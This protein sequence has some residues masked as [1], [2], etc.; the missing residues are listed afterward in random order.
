MQQDIDKKKEETEKQME[1]SAENTKL[2]D[3]MNDLQGKRSV[4]I[5]T[6]WM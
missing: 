3:K 2:Q 4:L 5:K 1:Y 6:I